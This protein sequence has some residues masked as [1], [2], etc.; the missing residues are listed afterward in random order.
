MADF[1]AR[2][3]ERSIAPSPAV[4]PV[5]APL[6]AQGP[7]FASAISAENDHISPEPA[8]RRDQPPISNRELTAV[9]TL[10][11]TPQDRLASTVPDITV[12]PSADSRN[13]LQEP[14][15]QREHD[16]N[17]V[18]TVPITSPRQIVSGHRG[19]DSP[20]ET[21]LRPATKVNASP[22]SMQGK[23]TVNAQPIRNESHPPPDPPAAPLVT[24][25]IN[26]RKQWEQVS[27]STLPSVEFS[28]PPIR[29]TIGRVEVRALF[30][31]APA[32]APTVQPRSHQPL[33][34]EEY[35]RQRN[36]GQR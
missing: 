3:A 10:S 15:G 18:S 14:A 4:K 23:S 36:G 11:Y 32:I 25:S 33:S 16:E 21:S 31:A 1:L 28:P 5:I 7:Q 8:L 29:I 13:S 22:P 24:P 9:E 35:L 27:L 34:L 26:Q 19:T 30:P 2:L 20:S 17:G 6:F 12:R